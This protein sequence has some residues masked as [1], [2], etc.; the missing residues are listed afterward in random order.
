M[1]EYSPPEHLS[2]RAKALW[3][4]VV[5]RRVD[6]PEQ[7]ALLQ[8]ALEALDGAD[9]CREVIAREGRT[10]KTLTTGTIHK[11]QAVDMEKEYRAAFSKMW[12]ALNLCWVP[13]HER[14]PQQQ[15][16]QDR[17]LTELAE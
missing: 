3:R 8:T 6:H 12:S 13:A 9:S 14:R 5:P 15:S 16:A 1:D 4:E 7:F 10:V 2:D 11:H 17:L